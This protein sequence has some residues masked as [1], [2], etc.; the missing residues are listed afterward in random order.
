MSLIALA[1]AASLQTPAIELRPLGED[2]QVRYSLAQPATVL[3]FDLP[4]DDYR[5]TNWK[6][7]DPAVRIVA[8]GD[9]VR[10]ERS[11]GRAFSTLS[12]RLRARY[13]EVPKNYAP[14]SPYSDGSL[15]IY[16]GQ[17]HAC[18]TGPC[19]PGSSW[20][21]RVPG[22]PPI[23]DRGDGTLVYVGRSKPVA[24]PHVVSVIDPGLPASVRA[25]LDALLPK[26]TAYFTAAFGPLDKRPM[27]FASLD[28]WPRPD[29]GLSYQGGTLPGQV[30]LH[31]YGSD[32]RRHSDKADFVPWFFAHEL[33]HFYH[34]ARSANAATSEEEAWIHEGGAEAFAALALR[35]FGEVAYVNRRIGAASD[36]CAAGLAKLSDKPLV[37]AARLGAFDLYYDCGLLLQLAIDG[38]LR[39]NSG[40]RETLAT[41]WADFLD[42]TR[43]GA[44]WTGETFLATAR[45]RGLT[46][47]TARRIA[48]LA[49]TPQHLSAG[50]LRA[51]LAL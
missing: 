23:M 5:Q 34:G 38:E 13:R 44:P 14:F 10:A 49:G 6:P 48:D 24:N 26:L 27:L 7:E 2:W 50:A 16:T 15:L 45:A 35:M 29:S 9:A 1:A 33:A 51:L 20:T 3:H 17:F 22:K 32:W 36:R 28:Q 31:F 11:D 42:R 18:A 25:Q 41:L 21:I 30:F 43:A 47:P 4:Y 39:R 12:F 40:G 37:A 8:E 46:E 19:A